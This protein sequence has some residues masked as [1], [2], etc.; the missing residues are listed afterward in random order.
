M[1]PGS[2][3]VPCD[4][5]FVHG[6]HEWL[7]LGIFRK[8]CPGSVGAVARVCDPVLEINHNWRKNDA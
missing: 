2:I 6:E 5:D 3:E 7:F 8:Q 4:S 1:R